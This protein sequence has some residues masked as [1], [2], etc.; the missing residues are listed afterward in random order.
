[1]LTYFGGFSSHIPVVR[2][3]EFK[4]NACPFVHTLGLVSYRRFSQYNFYPILKHVN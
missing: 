3:I 1:M 4:S 2:H